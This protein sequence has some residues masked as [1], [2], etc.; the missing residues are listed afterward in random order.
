MQSVAP[1]AGASLLG[2]QWR[3]GDPAGRE[4][5]IMGVGLTSNN[6][7]GTTMMYA[8]DRAVAAEWRRCKRMGFIFQQ[9]GV[10]WR[11]DDYRAG[12][13]VELGNCNGAL[14]TYRVGP[15]GRVTRMRDGGIRQ[16]AGN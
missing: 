2:D 1:G 4:G 9:P 3:P 16:N 15:T 11:Q 5:G 6:T 10:G 13:L 12:D 8:W 14:A 7:G